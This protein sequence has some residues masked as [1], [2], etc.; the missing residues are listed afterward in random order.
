M[1]PQGK[2][3]FVW[4][5][6]ICCISMDFSFIICKIKVSPILPKWCK[7][8]RISAAPWNLDNTFPLTTL[9]SCEK[10]REVKGIKMCY[11]HIPIPPKEC[12]FYVLQTSTNINWKKS[13]FFSCGLYILVAQ[14]LPWALH[15]LYVQWK[16]GAMLSLT[17]SL[18]IIPHSLIPPDPGEKAALNLWNIAQF[19]DF[20]VLGIIW[21][22][23]Y[24]RWRFSQFLYPSRYKYRL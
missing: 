12:N 5:Q 23:H 24:E 16:D 22:L 2:M 6:D 1:N 19:L 10:E 13:K 4:I 9:F 8:F 11:I 18:T 21:P 20:S 17:S 15:F 7:G 14:N 3:P